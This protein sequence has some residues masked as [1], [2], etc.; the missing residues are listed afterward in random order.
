MRLTQG[1]LGAVR[2]EMPLTNHTDSHAEA[3]DD[4]QAGTASTDRLV[5]RVKLMPQEPEPAPARRWRP[6]KS[7]LLLTIGPVA[8]GVLSWLAINAFKSDPAPAEVAAVEAVAAEPTVTRPAEAIAVEPE[9]Q[10]QLPPPQQQEQEQQQQQPPAPTSAIDEVIPDVP[11]SALDTIRGTVR[12]SVRVSIDN[13]GTVVD[14]AAEDRGPSRYFERLSVEAAKKWTFTP[15]AA[16]EPRIML[17]KFNFTQAGA[18]A[19]ASPIP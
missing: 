6:S 15:A 19:Q 1:P 9:V 17:V 10:P 7:A 18:T 8:A 2:S 13:Q 14:T 12:V 16:E 3:G 5:I 4:A 11:Q